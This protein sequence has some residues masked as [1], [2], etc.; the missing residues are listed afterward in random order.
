MHGSAR[1]GV[2]EAFVHAVLDA[3]GLAAGNAALLALAAAHVGGCMVLIP[4][5][6]A[7]GYV[8]ADALNMTLRIAGSCW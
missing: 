3:R 1:A 4:A 6:G 7:A 2:T 5:A 8:L